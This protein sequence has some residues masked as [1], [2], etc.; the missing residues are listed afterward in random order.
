[1]EHSE[2]E[3]ST[4]YNKIQLQ[5]QALI[6]QTASD[7]GQELLSENLTDLYLSNHQSN[8]LS[9]S[10]FQK[11]DLDQKIAIFIS[12]ANEN[13]LKYTKNEKICKEEL[14]KTTK[15]SRSTIIAQLN[16]EHEKSL[17]SLDN[18]KKQIDDHF[19]IELKSLSKAFS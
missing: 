17:L 11:S 19:K 3:I 8:L 9:Q 15:N 18:T 2:I 14:E 6:A 13:N 4:K 5:L 12:Q 1:M 10:S 7:F 16:A